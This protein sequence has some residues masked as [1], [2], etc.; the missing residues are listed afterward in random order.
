MKSPSQW[1]RGSAA[2]SGIDPLERVGNAVHPRLATIGHE[3]L[4]HVK[5][6]WQLAGPQ[7]FQPCVGTAFDEPL[8]VFVHGIEA[9]DLRTFAPR[10]HFDEEQ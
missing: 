1:P 4:D 8:L 3:D 5:A 6:P 2:A 9:T 10:F 7:F